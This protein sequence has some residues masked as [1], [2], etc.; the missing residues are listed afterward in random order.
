ML[1][2]KCTGQAGRRGRQIQ[3]GGERKQANPQV[4]PGAHQDG[5]KSCLF[6][7]PLILTTWHS[8]R[9]WSP[10]SQSQTHTPGPGVKEAKKDLEEGRAVEGPA[11][12]LHQRGVKVSLGRQQS[13]L[14]AD[15]LSV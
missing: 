12:S 1:E 10:S 7:L 8:C 5:L 14:G 9:S 3:S 4:Q 13:V 15:N 6:L 11:A 2:L